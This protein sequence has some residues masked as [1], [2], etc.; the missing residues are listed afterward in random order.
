MPPTAA[1]AE[2][3]RAIRYN[4][5]CGDRQ[6]RISTTIPHVA[7]YSKSLLA[8]CYPSLPRTRLA[9]PKGLLTGHGYC[10]YFLFCYL[11]YA[12]Y[13]DCT[14]LNTLQIMHAL[15]QSIFYLATLRR[16]KLRLYNVKH[17]LIMGAFNQSM[18]SFC[19]LET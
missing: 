6:K 17:T 14:M 12:I 13:C 3:G 16:N 8:P 10:Y 5:F 15:N 1:A 7:F 19:Y 11:L 2:W 9:T 18:F 4:L